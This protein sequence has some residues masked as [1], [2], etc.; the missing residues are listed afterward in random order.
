MNIATHAYV[1]CL[2][3]I[4]SM[5]KHRPRHEYKKFKRILLQWQ[6]TIQETTG[7]STT[8]LASTDLLTWTQWCG[9]SACHH[10][11]CAAMMRKP[12]LAADGQAHE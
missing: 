10:I 2:E 5:I 12:G 1:C 4:S 11:A 9:A 8:A 3:Q 6:K 7:F